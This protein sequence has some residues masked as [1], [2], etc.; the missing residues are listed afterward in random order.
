MWQA[1]AGYAV[2]G[3]AQG[4]LLSF[5]TLLLSLVFPP[6]VVVSNALIA[7]VWLRL[8]PQKG[9]I[10]VAIALIAGTVVASFSGSPVIPAAL[11]ASFWA[12]VVLMAYLLRRTV[13]LN[14]ALLAGAVLALAGVTI[15]YMVLDDPSQSWQ[16]MVEHVRSQTEVAAGGADNNTRVEEWLATAGTWMTGFSAATQFVVAV[17]SLLLARAWQA[18]MFNPG[19]LQEEFHGLRFGRAAGAIGLLIVA[20]SVFLDVELLKNLA[21][22]LLVV[23]TLQGLAVL[24]ALATQLRVHPLLLVSLYVFLLLPTSIKVF[25]MLGLVDT[26]VDFR[27]RVNVQKRD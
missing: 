2:R 20:A 25:G 24:H 23:F 13:S 22:V 3:P 17:L 14:L 21:I 15:A 26:W 12:P 7:L 5:S 8:G 18:R 19:G 1:L 4:A 10:C 16:G 9:L 27:S 11:M 6:L